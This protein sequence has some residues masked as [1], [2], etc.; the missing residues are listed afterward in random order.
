MGFLLTLGLETLQLLLKRGV[1]ELDDI[2]NNM[3]GAMIGYSCFAMIILIVSLLKGKQKDVKRTLALQMPLIIM[4]ASFTTIFATYANQE[5]GNLSI[6]YIKKVDADN[7][8]V[9]SD[10]KYN[11]NQE[12]LTVYKTKQYSQ[13][14]TYQFAKKFF[15]SIGDTI[16]ES[17]T[18][19]YDETA[20]YYSVGGDSFWMDYLGGT[21]SFTD[22]D[23]IFADPVINTESDATEEVI[24]CALEQY[25]IELPEGLDFSNDTD[26]KYTFTA[27]KI[28]INGTMYDGTLS[29]EYYENE[30]IGSIRG[31][32]LQCEYY[33]D[34]NVISEAEA[35]KTIEEGKFN[36]TSKIDDLS[37]KTGQV[38]IQ[39]IADSKGYYQP[40]Y[41]F[42]ADIN[43]ESTEIYIPAIE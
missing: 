37:I 39:Y 29:C 9:D 26:G 19:L 40:V 2:L 28:N 1:F 42:E 13:E 21:Y 3:I 31:N 11:T 25:G 24:T 33:K 7:L 5:L 17:R 12:S 4:I 22:Y 34:F 30:K 38:A 23:T 27:N 32:I 20:I 6:A 16:D 14:E 35:Y 18:D 10:E 15:D 36:I 43:G 41:I 8:T